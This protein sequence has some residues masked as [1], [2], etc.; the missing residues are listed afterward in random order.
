M[1]LK[2]YIKDHQKP[3]LLL[4][5]SE[6]IVGSGGTLDGFTVCKMKCGYSITLDLEMTILA[7][8][9]RQHAGKRRHAGVKR[10]F[11]LTFL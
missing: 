1:A 11:N 10:G 7:D 5:I 3:F 9:E 4:L 2:F 8:K 6:I